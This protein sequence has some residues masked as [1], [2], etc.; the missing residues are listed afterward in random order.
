MVAAVSLN[1]LLTRD[2]GLLDT[3]LSI[4]FRDDEG[5]WRSVAT[6]RRCGGAWRGSALFNAP[7]RHL[8][9]SSSFQRRRGRS[10]LRL[11]PRRAGLQT[12]LLGLS[13]AV[14]VALL[15]G[16]ISRQHA[17]LEETVVARAQAL[18]PR[19][20]GRYRSLL[21]AGFWTSFALSAGRAGY[22]A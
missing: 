17:W 10:F 19:A 20:H 6:F 3:R 7:W 13:L 9:R 16:H 4:A 11:H 18:S 8:G 21:R 1:E 22:C 12:L 14:A 5:G 2:P 15:V